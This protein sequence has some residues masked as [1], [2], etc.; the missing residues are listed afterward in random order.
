MISSRFRRSAVFRGVLFSAFFVFSYI[1]GVL[2]GWR[3][4]WIGMAS[5]LMLATMMGNAAIMNSF[6]YRM[7]R[8]IERGDGTSIRTSSETTAP[9]PRARAGGPARP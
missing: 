2:Y 4:D 1:C 5:C 6:V 7:L 3:E 8:D 9:V